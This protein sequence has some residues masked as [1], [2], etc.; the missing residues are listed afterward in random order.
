MIRQRV[1]LAVA[2]AV[3][4]TTALTAGLAAPASA[5]ISTSPYDPGFT[6]NAGDLVGVGSDTIEIALDNIA[7]GITGTAGYNASHA[8]GRI[9]SFAAAP[10]GEIV[11]RDG[12][13]AITRPNGSGAGKSL[14]HGASNNADV[15]F[16]RSSSSLNATE[17]S[18]GLQQIP[19]AVDGLKLA[20]SSTTNAPAVI[21]PDQMV[22]IYSGTI[23]NWNQIGG[24]DGV[25]KPYVPQAG[26]GTLSFFTAQLTAANGGTAVTLAPSV[27][28]TQEHSDADIKSNPNAVVPFSTA[29]SKGLTTIKLEKGF[30]AYRAVYDVV[31]GTDYSSTTVGAK[32]KAA[33]S[34]SGFV[35]SDAARPLIEAAGFYQ[36][37]RSSAGGVC[38]IPTQ[39]AVSTFVTSSLLDVD[40]TLAAVASAN[41]TIELTST[42]DAAASPAG[43]VT[44]TDTD[45]STVLGT[46]AVSGGKAVKT[47]TG[48]AAGTHN[49]SSVFTPTEGKPFKSSDV[50]TAS[51]K[52]LKA[53]TV[54]V[55]VSPAASTFGTSHTITVTGTQG[56]GALTG[57]VTVNVGPLTT[58]VNVVNGSGS[59]VTPAD[60][61]TGAYTV[62]AS[63]AGSADAFPAASTSTLSV[64]KAGTTTTIKLSKS[65]VKVKK[66]SK[67]TITVKINGSS[68]P[69][70]GKVTIKSGSKTVG[71]GTVRNGKV[72]I[73]IKKFSKKG[74]YK[75]KA[76][77]S[78]A[79]YY[80][81]STS[82]T[83]KLKVTK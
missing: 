35:C 71:T 40:N 58:V 78:G 26:S 81:A 23:T 9:A 66:T 5:A 13:T 47:L 45:T 74:T 43:T 16:A 70:N 41:G 77:F 22:K 61:P 82:K 28:S 3:V 69:A 65:K 48:V 18:D 4:A 62:T 46:V 50:S 79:A 25:I 42:V 7:K 52:I 36:L 57:P 60:L 10:A 34:E 76:T 75:L 24:K 2:G 54:A 51:A 15:S 11:L 63:Y 21:T 32:L 56:T 73:T 83:V 37:A 8:D 12:S 68:L 72:T 33:F 53:S 1:S 38:G 31:R 6:P 80:G 17:V 27:G 49:Y 64:A 20:V 14:L 39:S 55:S 29:R 59:F 67:A 30:R 19:F 44:F